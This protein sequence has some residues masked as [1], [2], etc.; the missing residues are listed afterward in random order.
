MIRKKEKNWQKENKDGRYEHEAYSK[1]VKWGD[2]TYGLITLV[3]PT[4][5][6]PLSRA[7]H[8]AMWFHFIGGLILLTLFFVCG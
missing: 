5:G 3:T 4:Y 7:K 6:T 8:I 2:P 1:V